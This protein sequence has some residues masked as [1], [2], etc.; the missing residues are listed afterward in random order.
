MSDFVTKK[1]LENQLLDAIEVPDG[2]W[3]TKKFQH[4]DPAEWKRMDIFDLFNIYELRI[5]QLEYWQ[6]RLLKE[7]EDLAKIVEGREA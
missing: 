7:V 3:P 2:Y 4:Y 1:E 5:D 6:A